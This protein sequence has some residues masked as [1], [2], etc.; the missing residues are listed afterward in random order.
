VKP[1]ARARI[2]GI[3]AITVALTGCGGQN[4]AKSTTAFGWVSPEQE[5]LFVTAQKTIP[6][7]ADKDSAMLATQVCGIMA[8]AQKADKASAISV[9]KAQIATATGAST[10]P[11]SDGKSDLVVLWDSA[12][13]AFC[14]KVWLE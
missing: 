5:Q 7:V 9:A 11:R 14:P 10:E 3:V 8:D 1:P 4:A 6:Q 2:L 13:H 12:I